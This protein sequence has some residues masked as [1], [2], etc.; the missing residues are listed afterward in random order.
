[1]AEIQLVCQI[2][3]TFMKFSQLKF[4]QNLLKFGP[5]GRNPAVSCGI[6]TILCTSK[7]LESLKYFSFGQVSLIKILNNFHVKKRCDLELHQPMRSL[8]LDVMP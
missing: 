7:A 1:M 3:A 4:W 5:Y 8:F 2:S 6:L